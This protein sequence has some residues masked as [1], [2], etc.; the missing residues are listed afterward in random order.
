MLPR[1]AEALTRAKARL[2]RLALYPRPVVS[3]RARIVV[4]PWF[5]RIPGLRRYDGY[6]LVRTILLRREDASDDLITHE[7]CHLWQMQHRPAHVVATYLT[8]R[9]SRNPYEREA[10]G[11]VELTRYG[12]GGGAGRDGVGVSTGDSIGGSGTGTGAGTEVGAGA[13]IGTGNGAGAG[14]GTGTGTG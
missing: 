11:A 3:D 7:L 6:A 13:G 14:V 9:Y 5:F 1:H 4:A 10:R 12:S 2:D 8:T